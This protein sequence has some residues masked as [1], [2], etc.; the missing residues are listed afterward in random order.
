[1]WVLEIKFKSHA[2]AANAF[3]PESCLQPIIKRLDL[4]MFCINPDKWHLSLQGT[5]EGQKFRETQVKACRAG[6][7]S[8]RTRDGQMPPEPELPSPLPSL[9]HHSAP[10]PPE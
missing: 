4:R 1:M 9:H 8:K 5:E 3:P 10:G 6:R 2:C 7:R